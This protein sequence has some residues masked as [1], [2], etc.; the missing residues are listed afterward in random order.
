MN[1]TYHLD[2]SRDS[3]SSL[4]MFRRSI[5][6]YAAVRVHRTMM[7]PEPTPAMVFGAAFHTFI[8]EPDRF[9]RDYAVSPT[10][11]RRTKNGKEAAAQWAAENAGK[12]PVAVEDLDLMEAM[13]AGL[14]RNRFAV[15]AIDSAGVVETPV[16]WDCEQT[17][18]A[19]KCRPDKVLASGLIVDLKTTNEIEPVEFAKTVANFGYHRQAALYLA[20]LS[21]RGITGP[22]LFVAVSKRPPHESACY[23]LDPPTIEKGQEQNRLTLAELAERKLNGDWAG[24]WSNVIETVSLPRWAL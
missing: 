1:E 14:R 8:L 22:F 11:D 24:R 18:L 5:E 21:R 4:E 19:L 3:H 10:F 13:L 15:G 20:G 9:Q 6:E 12:I 16:E 23:V 2:Y 17:G 7:P